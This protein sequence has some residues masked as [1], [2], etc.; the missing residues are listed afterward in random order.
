MTDESKTPSGK[1]A[2]CAKPLPVLLQGF[3]SF[4]TVGERACDRLFQMR[5]PVFEAR[6]AFIWNSLPADSQD[7][8]GA[9]CR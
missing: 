3:Q 5:I 8:G 9:G 6:R 4:F 2:E 7:P 1:P